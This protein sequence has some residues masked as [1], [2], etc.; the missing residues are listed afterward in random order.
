M[1]CRAA[2]LLEMTKF[3]R[4]PASPLVVVSEAKQSIA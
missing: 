1:D 4:A 2:A 3:L